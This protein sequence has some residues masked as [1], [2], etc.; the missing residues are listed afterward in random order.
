MMEKSSREQ[1]AAERASRRCDAKYA[2]M[3]PAY[4]ESK[5]GLWF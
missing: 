1:R 3:I 4:S 2:F 5:D